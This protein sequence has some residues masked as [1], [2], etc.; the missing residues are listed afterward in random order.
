MTTPTAGSSRARSNAVDSSDRV[1]GRKAFRTSGRAIVTLAIPSAVSYRMSS[2]SPDGRHATIGPITPRASTR[3]VQASLSHMPSTTTPDLRA[4][5][6]VAVTLPP[7]PEWAGI[8]AGAWDAGAALLPVDHRLPP[9]QA[10][11]LIDR[12]A[13]TVLIDD[14]GW[15]RA[16]SGR[17]AGEGVALVVHTSG[18][19]RVPK[20]VEFDRPA[21]D[22]A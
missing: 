13:P 7:G 15:H 22:A 17:P 18:T 8:L 10:R 1:L 2:Y 14:G 12:A 21:I 5:D 9:S 19:G 16:R 4:G 3:T 20:L 6:L 11:D